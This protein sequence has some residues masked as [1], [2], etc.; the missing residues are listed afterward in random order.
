MFSSE[1]GVDVFLM[2]AMMGNWVTPLHSF[3][4]Y[5]LDLPEAFALSFPKRFGIQPHVNDPP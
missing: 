3:N 4:Y 5:E 1:R 2:E